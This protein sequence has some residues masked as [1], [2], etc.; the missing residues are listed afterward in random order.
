MIPQNPEHVEASVLDEIRTL[1][2]G[3]A[4]E[5]TFHPDEQTVGAYRIVAEA[6]LDRR[7][8]LI[9]FHRRLDLWFETHDFRLS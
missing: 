9:E 1:T 3:L 7:S 5:V 2:A 6:D 4:V 8:E